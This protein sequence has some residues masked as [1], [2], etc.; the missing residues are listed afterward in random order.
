MPRLLR[1]DE[2][3]PDV[4]VTYVKP[5]TAD[6]PLVY[7]QTSRLGYIKVKRS[8]AKKFCESHG[9]APK[10]ETREERSARLQ[11]ERTARPQPEPGSREA[12]AKTS[13]R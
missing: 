7:I 10:W 3:A 13:R 1:P 2:Q 12:L 8:E 9:L 11:R 4:V 6:D 5:A